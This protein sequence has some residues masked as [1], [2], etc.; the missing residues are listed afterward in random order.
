[1]TK[2]C[3]LICTWYGGREMLSRLL[4]SLDGYT[5]YDIVIAVNGVGK[6]DP[7]WLGEITKQANVVLSLKDDNYELGAIK[8]LLEKTRYDE[9]VFLQDTF[10]IKNTD[11]FEILFEHEDYVGKSVEYGYD[12]QMYFGKYRRRILNK[13]KFPPLPQ[14]KLDAILNEIVFTKLYKKHDPTTLTFDWRFKDEYSSREV[15]F[16]RENMRLEDEYLIKRKGHW[17]GKEDMDLS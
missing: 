6:T 15:M 5:K 8:A 10:E 11:I 2:R 1:M 9:F 12:F 4:A 14:T 13:M 16:G 3:I 7:E 17:A